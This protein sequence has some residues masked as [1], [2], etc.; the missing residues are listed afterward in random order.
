[1]GTIDILQ[2][3]QDFGLSIRQIPTEVTSTYSI[4]HHKEGNEIV[5][6]KLSNHW[7][8]D[9]FKKKHENSPNYI[10]CDETQ[11]I[12]RALTKETIIPKNAGYWMCKQMLDNNSTVK[13][14]SR[15]DNLAPTLKESIESFLNNR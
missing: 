1:M 8:Y 11:T 2:I 10:F 3:I 6:K 9:V 4:V 12:M 5:Y 15:E 13:W 14:D 7:N